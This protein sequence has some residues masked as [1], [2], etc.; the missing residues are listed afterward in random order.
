MKSWSRAGK[1]AGRD[2]VL[3]LRGG[4]DTLVISSGLGGCFMLPARCVLCNEEVPQHRARTTL[5]R[6]AMFLWVPGLQ[7][8]V[9]FQV[10]LEY[11]LCSQHLAR[12]RVRLAGFVAGAFLTGIA[13]ALVDGWP[14]AVCLVAMVVFALMAL[15][16]WQVIRLLDIDAAQARIRVGRPFAESFASDLLP[17]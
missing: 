16:S 9:D 8:A 1:E 10:Q 4:D 5:Q 17:A 12:R 13:S 15:R 14:V 7:A 6:R 3:C 11:S 2:E